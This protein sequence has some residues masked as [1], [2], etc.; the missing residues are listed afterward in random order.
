M[1]KDLIIMCKSATEYIIKNR[2][3]SKKKCEELFGSSGIEVFERLKGLGV[4]KNIGYGDLQVTQEAKRLIDTKYFENLIK[5]ID[6][7]EY[8]RY[9]SNKSKEATIKSTRIAKIALILSIL[10][11]TGLP[12][13]F[14]KWLWLIIL[15]SIY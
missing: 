8:D 4:G 9:L 14:F 15:Q 5:Q 12:Q 2:S 10:S 3:I 1:D 13:I 6:R 7:D 11:L